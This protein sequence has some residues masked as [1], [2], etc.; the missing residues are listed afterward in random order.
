M[1]ESATAIPSSR[2]L[3]SRA[4]AGVVIARAAGLPIP[5]TILADR[6]GIVRCIDQTD[7][8]PTRS[9]PDRVL[10]AVQPALA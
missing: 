9:R 5:T 7:D 2:A 3:L 8:Y 1:D 4:L 10:G 6:D